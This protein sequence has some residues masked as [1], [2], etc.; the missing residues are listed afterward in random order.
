[1]T[2]IDHCDD[3]Q[4]AKDPDLPEA[5]DTR[6]LPVWR[7]RWPDGTDVD[8][9]AVAGSGRIL[10]RVAPNGRWQRL[11]YQGLHSFDLEPLR[12]RMWLRQTFV[13]VLSF[14]GMAPC[15]TSCVTGWRSLTST[16]VRSQS[17]ARAAGR[18][19]RL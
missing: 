6:P 12:E 13:L 19:L 18:S 17:H 1:V 4:D 11:P 9:D 2:Q 16:R 5:R 14:A 15:V 8:A 3:M 7:I 10:L